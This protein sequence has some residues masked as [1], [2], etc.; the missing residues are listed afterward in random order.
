MFGCCQE[1]SQPRDAGAPPPFPF[2]NGARRT[3]RL[4]IGEIRS[5]RFIDGFATGKPRATVAGDRAR[6]P[7]KRT[8][9]KPQ[10]KTT[11]Q[12]VCLTRQSSNHACAGRKSA[13]EP[14]RASVISDHGRLNHPLDRSSPLPLYA[15]I[16][17]RLIG[18]VANGTGRTGASI[19][20][21]N[22]ASSFSS[23][24]TRFARLWSELV[25][26][27]LLTRSRGLGTFVSIRKVQERF[28]PGMNF[29]QQWAANGTPMQPKVLAF[30]RRPP[31]P[32]WRT[33]WKSLR[34]RWF[35]RSGG[36]VRRRRSGR[37]R[38][39]FLPAHLARLGRKR[40]ARLAAAP[41]LET[42][43]VARRRVRDRRRPRRRKKWNICTCRPARR[44]WC[45]TSAIGTSTDAWSSPAARFTGPISF[46]T[47]CPF[48][49]WRTG[50]EHHAAPPGRSRR[51]GM[52]RIAQVKS[53]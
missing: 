51:L 26:E 41:A 36:C 10:P 43:S 34:A 45:A 5:V 16:K 14:I 46:A 53:D 4:I 18:M 9:P 23:A 1:T 13:P 25:R 7:A 6:S 11:C 27:G 42:H 3:E 50:A 33:C 24:A 29:L 15:Q 39:P 37:H 52:R 17:Q 2:R 8:E 48:R 28:E 35:S 12:K 30:E 44:S 47:R 21:R 32:P 22:C 20:T 38:L 49:C 19:P 40:R 31:T